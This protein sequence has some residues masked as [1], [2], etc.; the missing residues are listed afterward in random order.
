M[1]FHFSWDSRVFRKLLIARKILVSLKIYSS[2]VV[3]MSYARVMRFSSHLHLYPED[4]FLVVVVCCRC[5]LAFAEGP[6]RIFCIS[7]VISSL[8]DSHCVKLIGIKGNQYVR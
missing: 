7:V 4:L 8:A 1:A 3:Q 6:Q 5:H 2:Q